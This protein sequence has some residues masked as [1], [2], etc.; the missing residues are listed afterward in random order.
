MHSFQVTDF[1]EPIPVSVTQNVVAVAIGIS[2]L[3]EMLGIPAPYVYLKYLSI[4]GTLILSSMTSLILTVLYIGIA[5]VGS[6]V[7]YI[8]YKQFGIATAGAAASV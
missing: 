1:V 7:N 2:A 6:W 8:R 4:P 3:I 5:G